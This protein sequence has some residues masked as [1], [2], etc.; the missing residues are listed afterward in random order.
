MGLAVL[1]V[2]A[3]G[4][5][6]PIC[7]M[8]WIERMLFDAPMFA[9]AIR[10]QWSRIAAT[11]RD[12]ELIELWP[13]I[14]VVPLPERRRRRIGATSNMS[15][16]NIAMLVGPELMTCDQF[17]AVC[18]SRRVD[19]LATV[20]R[21]STEELLTRR[22]AA[23]VAT[24]LY[25]IHD[26]ACEIDRRSSEL[27]TLSKQLGESY[28]E[29]SLLYK[30]SANMTVNQPPAE[31]L[32]DA[33]RELQ[34]VLGL[35]WMA[36]QLGDDARRIGELRGMTIAVGDNAPA[37]KKL[38]A[39]GRQLLE[40]RPDLSRTVIVDDTRTLGIDLL[41][42][43]TRELVVV[44]LLRDGVAYGLLF[45][46]DKTDRSAHLSSVDSTLA[47]ALANSLAIFIENTMLYEDMQGMFFGTLHALTSSIDAKDSYTHGHSERVALL[48]RQLAAAHG[49]SPAEVDRVYISGLV[50]DVGKIGVPEAVLC[51]AGHLTQEEYDLIKLHPTIGAEIL[52]DIRQMQDLVPGVLHHHE[53][54]DGGGY[55]ARIGGK[56][57][58]L[59]GRLICLADS[60][61]AMTSSRTY[62]QALT[63]EQALNEIRR[64]ASAQ[65]DPEL[66]ATFVELDFGPFYDMMQRHNTSKS[67]RHEVPK[68]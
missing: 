50:H 23:R 64:C 11:P 40:L 53:R 20:A 12:P 42:S 25:W 2:D 36:L 9:A 21:I 51:K 60:F 63:R 10:R 54:W 46:G 26:D 33:C 67:T 49:L 45:G 34:Q 4:H 14:W 6:E 31:F 65:F 17:R 24:M 44:P 18:D 56:E 1:R 52:K 48:S 22:E 59:F 61:D 68:P 43:L 15:T 58:P 39:A 29:I 38:R 47:N 30:L 19:Y 62:R 8:R 28:E 35:K 32:T 55:P 5:A 7:G 13:G 3:H 41:A 57:I 27:Q 37:T 66:A 16:Q